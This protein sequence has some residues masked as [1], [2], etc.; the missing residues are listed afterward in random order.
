MYVRISRRMSAGRTYEYVQLCEAYRNKEGKPRTRIILNLG[1]KEKLDPSRVDK[2]IEALLPYGSSAQASSREVTKPTW[3]IPM[4]Y[5]DI[6]LLNALWDRLGFQEVVDECLGSRRIGS[7]LGELVRLSVIYRL[8][9]LA[10]QVGLMTWSRNIWSGERGEGSIIYPD[11]LQAMDGLYHAKDCLDNEIFKRI[12]VNVCPDLSRPLLYVIPFSQAVEVSP[13]KNARRSSGPRKDVPSGVFLLC[14]KDNLPL[15]HDVY[16]KGLPTKEALMHFIE[17]LRERNQLTPWL[18]ICQ[19]SEVEGLL[20]ETLA[21]KGVH[22]IFELWRKPTPFFRSKL[23][24]RLQ[25][26]KNVEGA[27]FQ[28]KDFTRQG[29]RYVVLF[30]DEGNEVERKRRERLLKI[31]QREF[32]DLN[33]KYRQGLIREEALESEAGLLLTD[34]GLGGAFSPLLIDGYGVTLTANKEGPYLIPVSGSVL[35]L[36]TDLLPPQFSSPELVDLYKG[37]LEIQAVFRSLLNPAGMEPEFSSTQDSLKG[38]VIGAILAL[39]VERLLSRCLKEAGLPFS[40]QA[41]L[42]RLKNFNL[43]QTTSG[44]DSVAQPAK[45]TPIMARLMEAVGLNDLCPP[46]GG[47]PATRDGL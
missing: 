15:F 28:V 5:G 2:I 24:N 34:L 42:Q 4:D 46:Q 25:V 37:F 31:A 33:A 32:Q 21:Q 40:P 45:L 11:F 39:W 26:F 41:A 29:R 44:H 8:T 17:R 10:S 18:L 43:T 47:K 16:T 30:G 14:S 1:R 27:S 19:A 13:R 22:W 36:S 3:G 20:A 6:V 35:V 9:T 7:E 38:N 23:F 12:I